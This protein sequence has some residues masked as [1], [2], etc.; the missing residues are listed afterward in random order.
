MCVLSREPLV[1]DIK[2]DGLSSEY[3]GVILS[4]KEVTEKCLFHW[5]TFPI[6]LP[7]PAAIATKNS[8]SFKKKAVNLRDVYV[9]PS[10]DE[11]D[12]V[13]FDVKGD[14]RK[15]SEKQL[16]TIQEWGEFEVESLNFCGQFHKWKLSPWLQNGFFRAHETLMNDLAL[17]L[18]FIMITGWNRIVSKFFSVSQAYSSLRLGLFLLC[19]CI[20]GLPSLLSEDSTTKLLE[21]RSKYLVA[22]LIVPRNLD[23]DLDFLCMFI[24][25]RLQKL[26]KDSIRCELE[27]PPGIP[28]LYQTPKGVNVD[29]RLFNKEVMK[30]ALPILTKLLEKESRGWFIQFKEKLIYEL[31][32]QKLT[33]EENERKAN[34][35]V[36]NEYLRRVYASIMNDTFI[37]E[38]GNGIGQLLIEQA[39]SVVLM[40]RAIDDIQFQWNILSSQIKQSLMDSCPILSKIDSW[41]KMKL[42]AAEIKYKV[43]HQFDAHEAALQACRENQLH[44]AYYFLYRDLVFIRER[45][46]VLLKELNRVKV[47]NRVFQ[48]RRPIWFPKNWIVRKVRRGEAEVIPTIVATRPIASSVQRSNSDGTYLVEKQ[49]SHSTNTSWVF[50]RWTNFFWRSWTWLWNALYYFGVVIP[51]HSPVGVLALM[52]VPPFMPDFEPNVEGDLVPRLSSVTHTMCSRLVALWRHISKSRTEFE[53]RP[54]RGFVGRGFTRLL[55]R[56]WN[57]VVKGLLGTL[58]IVILF[59]MICVVL[60]LLSLTLACTAVAWVPLAAVIFHLTCL[61]VYD[62]D[63]PSVTCV[64]WAIIPR[65][66]VWEVGVQSCLQPVLAIILAAFICP[67]IS[68]FIVIWALLKWGASRMWDTIMFHIVVKRRGR[69]PVS[70]GLLVKRIAGPGMTSNYYYQIV[71]EQCLI[72][73]EAKLEL[74]ELTA[75]YEETYLLIKQ[76]QNTFSEFVRICLQPFSATLLKEG[77]Y[78]QLEKEASE[79]HFALR[80]KVDQRIRSLNLG[81]SFSVRSKVR[82][83]KSD[84]QVTIRV[85]VPVLES[86]YSTRVFSRLTILEE[87]FWRDRMLTFRDW[88]GMNVLNEMRYSIQN[89]N[90][91]DYN[92][93]IREAEGRSNSDYAG[94]FGITKGRVNVQSPFLNVALF[95][96][97]STRNITVKQESAKKRMFP[98]KGI[99]SAVVSPKLKAPLLI[100]HPVQVAIVVYNR[101]ADDPIPLEWDSC[102]NVMK[103]IEESVR[104]LSSEFVDIDLSPIGSQCSVVGKEGTPIS[105]VDAEAISSRHRNSVKVNLASAEDITLDTDGEKVTY[106][107]SSYSTTV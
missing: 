74:E 16:K 47:P 30:E 40:Q 55:N 20:F 95:N 6:V 24:K 15:L 42:E 54:D 68:L 44:Q 13:A 38:L 41:V 94:S 92:E 37:R 107:H 89:A 12:S 69:I 65:A 75:F 85:I 66:L 50:W 76:P 101:E 23:D 49:I 70:D 28:Y 87:E 67:I 102:R 26:R 29:L 106:S 21:E 9:T 78:Q 64:K 14:A 8:N 10:F 61:L 36:M 2:V 62:F 80:E 39:H 35:A 103:V 5:K 33:D 22:E 27:A 58:G 52:T 82:M 90:L 4:L 53:T 97:V 96:P 3:S 81:L 25:R 17:A 48:W 99:S 57:Y 46:P 79:L 18:K 59:P 100:P 105:T 43:E 98:W 83:T 45:E 93:L 104:Q 34:I 88:T 72:A 60:S 73:F 63:V 86:F 1:V 71:P 51:W 84:L 32:S 77:L 7:P 31:K 19:D 56:L 11:V 91:S